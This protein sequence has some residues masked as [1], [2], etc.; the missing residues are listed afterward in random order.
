[1]FW[2]DHG[3]VGVTEKGGTV[4]TIVAKDAIVG[5]QRLRK[6]YRRLEGEDGVGVRL[7]A[8]LDS[9]LLLNLPP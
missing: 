3:V 7:G 1:M 4:T 5:W 8:I 6:N 2:E 9:Y